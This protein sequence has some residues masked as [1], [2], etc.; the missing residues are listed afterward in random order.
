M[1]LHPGVSTVFL[2]MVN[3]CCGEPITLVSEGSIAKLY[4]LSGA[5]K[6]KVY[7]GEMLF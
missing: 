1:E 4:T 7:K 2:P 5:R 6:A 3:F